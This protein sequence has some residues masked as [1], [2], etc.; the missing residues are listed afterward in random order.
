VEIR[1]DID[2]HSGANVEFQG[3]VTVL[4]GKQKQQF[5]LKL[6]RNDPLPAKTQTNK[7]DR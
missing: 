5:G 7:N 1:G 4:K 2:I 6:I 3:K